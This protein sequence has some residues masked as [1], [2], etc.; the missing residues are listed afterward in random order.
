MRFW[1]KR[2]FFSLSLSLSLSLLE[3]AFTNHF[4]LLL[5]VQY[6]MPLSS[7]CSLTLTCSL[8]LSSIYLQTVSLFS[9]KCAFFNPFSPS[10]LLL[11]MQSLTLS[12]SSGHFLM[13]TL[14]L[15]L[16]VH[17]LTLTL[18]VSVNSLHLPLFSFKCVISHSLSSQACIF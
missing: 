9:S 11:S 5:S 8:S 17:S 4:T 13:L 14:S 2:C 18:H 12:L 10:L 7:M 1:K 16:S 6:L 3:C 15:P